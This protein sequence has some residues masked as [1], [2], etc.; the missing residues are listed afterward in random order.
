MKKASAMPLQHHHPST[1]LYPVYQAESIN[2]LLSHWKYR[3]FEGRGL[4]NPTGRI[5]FVA[6]WF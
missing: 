5:L 4:L 6:S 2:I 1:N 3:C